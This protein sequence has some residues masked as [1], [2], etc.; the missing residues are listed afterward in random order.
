[1]HL[2]QEVRGP[3]QKE[4]LPI[5]NEIRHGLRGRVVGARF[6]VALQDPRMQ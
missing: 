2:P 4:P 1:M 3:P 6:V 5:A